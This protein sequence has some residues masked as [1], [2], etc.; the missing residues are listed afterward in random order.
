MTGRGCRT[1]F[2]RKFSDFAGPGPPQGHH[3]ATTG[4][5]LLP[6]HEGLRPGGTEPPS[7]ADPLH[8]A[9]TQLTAAPDGVRP[10]LRVCRIRRPAPN[11]QVAS[12]PGRFVRAPSAPVGAEEGDPDRGA[13]TCRGSPKV[14]KV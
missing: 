9:S 8:E 5:G 3:R 10:A 6:L 4:T 13:L 14:S 11:A 7:G 1:R 2:L 12:A